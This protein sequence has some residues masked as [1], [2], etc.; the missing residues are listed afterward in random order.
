MKDIDFDELDRAVSSLMTD[1]PGVNPETAHEP[2]VETSAPLA[3]LDVQQQYPE[4]PAAV[5]STPPFNSPTL[6]ASDP[7]Q[8]SSPSSLAARRG[9]RFMDVVH[10]S[11]DMRTSSSAP[12]RQGVTIAPRAT[13]VIEETSTPSVEATP[14][15]AQSYTNE[16]T[17]TP[18]VPT[19]NIQPDLTFNDSLPQTSPFLSGAKVEKRPLGGSVI[20]EAL[21]AELAK[22]STQPSALLSVD[23]NLNATITPELD[24]QLQPVVVVKKP[25]LPAELDS[26]LVAIESGESAESIPEPVVAPVEPPALLP[27]AGSI[28]QQ[29]AEQP[30]SGDSTHTPIYDTEE[31]HHALA[32]PA[33]KKSSWLW[34][35]WIILIVLL[36]AGAGAAVYFFRLI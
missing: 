29:Y 11:A 22:E 36:G 25:V 19:A 14:D 31:A 3:V 17:I 12:S 26:D 7:V 28:P 4:I 16:R 5:E 21:A 20:N 27:G 15:P 10:P 9:G 30:S 23:D 6:V 18:E 8:S 24:S 34:V 2:H 1:V 33:K 32:H 35:I 13:N